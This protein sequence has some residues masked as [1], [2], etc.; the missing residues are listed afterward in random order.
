MSLTK[1]FL[2]RWR[3]LGREKTRK[4]L[5]KH[6]EKIAGYCTKP[7]DFVIDVGAHSGGYA[8]H[9]SKLVGKSGKVI[10][11]EANPYIAAGLKK[12]FA[13]AHNVEVR[14]KAVSSISGQK[15][16][17]CLY[18]NDL[19]AQ[20]STIEPSMM[21]PERMPGVTESVEVET[22]HLDALVEKGELPT[23]HFLKIDTEGHEAHVMQGAQLILSKHRPPVLF[24]YSYLPGKLE[25]DTIQRMETLGYVCFDIKTDERVRPGYVTDYTDLIAITADR[26]REFKRALKRLY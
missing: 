22:E 21:N 20:C 4:L 25:P 24:E 26:E 15:V 2:M 19:T 16:Q 17:M 18:P 13:Q 10:A 5:E 3:L 9:Y 7:G 14:E 23:V 12:R 6:R 1:A 11:Y 8:N